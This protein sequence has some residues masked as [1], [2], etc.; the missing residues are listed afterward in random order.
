MK[1]PTRLK[2]IFLNFLRIDRIR[3]FVCKSRWLILQKHL[4]YFNVDNNDI[5]EETIKH[6]LSAFKHDAAFGM[7]NRM[8]IL[9]YPT[10]AILN[11]RM[12][13]K[14]LIVGPR[15]EDDIFMAKSLGLFDT[16]G[17]DLFSYSDMIELGDI[18]NTSYE[19]ESFDVILLGW[20]ISY[21]KN[22]AQVVKECDRLLKSGGYLG[23]GIESNPMQ[24]NDV[25][26]PP[27]VNTLNSSE[28]LIDLIGR[29]WDVV[30]KHDPKLDV[31]F[32]CAVIQRKI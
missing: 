12:N 16:I 8:T 14:I 11:K 9:L 25:I 2:K 20:M 31:P 3:F 1:Q 4:R 27:R 30:F 5:G 23:I 29:N 10:A 26:F 24:K 18:H 7:S 22:P 28:N 21:S 19:S 6:N 32:E 13:P 15:T 17:L